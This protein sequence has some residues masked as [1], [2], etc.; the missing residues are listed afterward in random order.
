MRRRRRKRIDRKKKN[1]ERMRSPR[2]AG[3][4]GARPRLASASPRRPSGPLRGSTQLL[5]VGT[6]ARGNLGGGRTQVQLP[7][8]VQAGQVGGGEVLQRDAAAWHE[9]RSLQQLPHVHPSVEAVARRAAYP[10]H[11]VADQLVQ[12]RALRT[13]EDGA[14]LEHPRPRAAA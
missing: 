10:G 9:V 6:V 8:R 2:P 14:L 5:L 13:G 3:A 1:R 7:G 12:T 4:G 11:A